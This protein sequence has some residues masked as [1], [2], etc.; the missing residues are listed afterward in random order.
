[1]FGVFDRED[2][3]RMFKLQSIYKICNTNTKL[4]FTTK[5]GKV[6]TRNLLHVSLSKS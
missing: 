3:L 1:M 5:N 2:S 4:F 6:W